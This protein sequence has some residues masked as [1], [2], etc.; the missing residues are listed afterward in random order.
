[1]YAIRSYYG[2]SLSLA[3]L[4]LGDVRRHAHLAASGD[5]ALA[6][7]AFVGTRGSTL[8]PPGQPAKHL[9][10]GDGFVPPVRVGDLHVD[11]ESVAVLC[12]RVHAEREL[13]LL[14]EALEHQLG[15]GVCLR[16]VGLIAALVV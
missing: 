16:L 7:V 8:A 4:D 9:Q 3:L 1:M 13:R 15:L 6:V 5:E 14:A 2:T 11:Q 10:R 12:Q